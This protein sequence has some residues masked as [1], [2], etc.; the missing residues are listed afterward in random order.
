MTTVSNFA[1]TII[2]AT[3]AMLLSIAFIGAAVGPA[4]PSAGQA[5]AS[6]QAVA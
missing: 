2:G 1:R 4:I 3:G 5:Q 6:V